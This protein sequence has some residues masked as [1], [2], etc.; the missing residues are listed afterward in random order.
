MGFGD[1]RKKKFVEIHE[2][3]EIPFVKKKLSPKIPSGIMR[4]KDEENE[5][6]EEEDEENEEENQEEAETEYE[7]EYQNVGL[8]IVISI[9]AI[10]LLA[11][12]FAFKF[13]II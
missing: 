11:I 7:P 12:Y 2:D 3:F 5:E 8:G 1:M 4:I 9:I 6:D 13:G 10:T